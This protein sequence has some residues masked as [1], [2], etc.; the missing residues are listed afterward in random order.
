MAVVASKRIHVVAGVLRDTH[1]RIFLAQRPPTGHLA[2]YWE[3]PGGKVELG[4]SRRAALRRELSE[5]IGITAWMMRPLIRVIHAYEERTVD[6]DIWLIQGWSGIGI[7]REGQATKWI[8]SSELQQTSLP[9]ADVPVVTALRLGTQYLITPEPNAPDDVEFLRD[10]E[11]TLVAAQQTSS[12][13][14]VVQL[15]IK[16]LALASCKTLI[17]RA[18]EVVR[19]YGAKLLLNG[20]PDDVRD[21]DVDGVHLPSAHLFELRTRPSG[22]DLVGASC[23][24][25]D[26]LRQAQEVADFAVLSPVMHTSSHAEVDPLGWERYE[27]YVAETTIPVFALGGMQSA[28]IDEAHRRGGQGIAAISGLWAT[29]RR[30]RR[31]S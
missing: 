14:Q 16:Q 22:F 29:Q 18:A 6:L 4:E 5:E 31:G 23:H 26:E 24:S 12:P 28:H 7:G 10:L 13:V 17:V 21:F 30:L 19:R 25:P 20:H 9:P 11:R 15:R 27:A 1:G 2:G 3:F 8:D